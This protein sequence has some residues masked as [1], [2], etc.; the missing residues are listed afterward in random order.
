M[1]VKEVIEALETIAPTYLQ[2][3]YDNSGLLIGQSE[4]K[5]T[6]IL[7]SLDLTEEVLQE[8]IK[9]KSNLIISHHPLIFN[10]LKRITG[11]NSVERIVATAIKQDINIYAIHTNLDNVEKGINSIICD[12]IG[13]KNRK[14]LAPKKEILRKLITF[15]PAD[16]A[17][18]VRMAIFDAGAGH[19]GDY[20]NCSFNAPG[21]GSFRGSEESNPFVGEKGKLHYEEEIRIESVYPVY[22]EESILNALFE[23]HPYE[24]VAYDIYFLGNK[25]DRVGAGMIGELESEIDEMEFLKNLKLTFGA[26]C[27]RHSRLLGN[28]IKKVA[29]CGGSGSFLIKNAIRTHADIYITGDVKY[30]D[31]FE[32]EDKIV[33]ADIGHFESEQYAKDLIYS[34]L[35]ENF[36]TFA[37]LIS[38]TNT[39][40]VNYI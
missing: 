15:C 39:N 10:G 2:E 1:K 30:H 35:N 37:V 16:H 40:S 22:L 20:D 36:S 25:Y 6:K 7:I 27:I 12:K 32:A 9:N 19:I 24:E 29:V 23:A 21:I 33:I 17:E 14:I 3:S 11:R 8:A 13:L 18:K 26:G 38:K 5:V 31:F 4:N 28:K 34:V